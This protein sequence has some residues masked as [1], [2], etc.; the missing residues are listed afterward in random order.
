MEVNGNRHKFENGNE[1]VIGSGLLPSQRN[2]K[3]TIHWFR[4]ELRLHDNPSLRLGLRGA[5]TYRCIFIIDTWFAGCS[6]AG[7]NKW[8]YYIFVFFLYSFWESLL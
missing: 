6:D 1:N 7:V 2:E 5:I 3:H 4:K 8:R